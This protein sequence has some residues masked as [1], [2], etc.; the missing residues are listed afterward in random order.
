MWAVFVATPHE[1]GRFARSDVLVVETGIG[2]AAAE[3]AARA[4]LGRRR[5]DGVLSVGFCGGLVPG[6]STGDVVLGE[7]V[8][9]LPVP[10]LE[11]HQPLEAAASDPGLVALAEEALT[12]A[13]LRYRRGACVTSPVLV[14]GPDR[15]R[16]LGQ[17]FP[18]LAVEMES[19]WLAQAARDAGASFLTV[20]A[21]LDGVDEA[22]PPADVL[23]EFRSLAG[24]SSLLRT[25]IVLGVRYLTR[26][27]SQIARL[28]AQAAKARGALRAFARAFF[29]RAGAGSV[30]SSAH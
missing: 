1:L 6:L 27:P 18:A 21:I 17:Q 12:A 26:H 10:L 25:G 2:R 30:C 8:Y 19:F 23:A 14:P 28:A 7:R 4:V 29:A 22:L 24:P 11:A 15:K 13:R 5:V 16:E 3:E 20:R 9:R